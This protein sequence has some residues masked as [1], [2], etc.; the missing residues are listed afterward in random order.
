M[1][2]FQTY[3]GGKTF[4]LGEYGALVNQQGLMLVTKPFFSAEFTCGGVAER[5]NDPCARFVAKHAGTLSGVGYR[6]SNPYGGLGGLGASSAEYLFWLRAFIMFSEG[7]DIHLD[8]EADRQQALAWYRDTHW[9]GEGLAPSGVD[10]VVIAH[11]QASQMG[12]SGVAGELHTAWS[13]MKE[14]RP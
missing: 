12:L 7:R 9:C 13:K 10:V 3:C 11:P 5:V 14:V 2:T 4:L 6:F 1:Q 8:R